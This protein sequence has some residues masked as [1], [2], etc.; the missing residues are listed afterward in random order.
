MEDFYPFEKKVNRARKDSKLFINLES[1][2]DLSNKLN[3]SRNI[4]FILNAAILS[5]MGKLGFFRA[6]A[7]IGNCSSLGLKTIITKGNFDE[8]KVL[9]LNEYLR[10]FFQKTDKIITVADPKHLIL[11]ITYGIEFFALLFLESKAFSIDYTQEELHYIN[12]V[13]NLIAS[14][15]ENAISYQTLLKSKIELE[16]KNQILSTIYDVNKDFSSLLSRDQV[17]NHLRYRIF[18]QLMVNRFVLFYKYNDYLEEIYNN[19]NLRLDNELSEILFNLKEVT[20]FEE[21]ENL[22]EFARSKLLSA[23]LFLACPIQ[24]QE[25]TKGLLIVGRK[26]NNSRFTDD[27]LRFIELLGNTLGQAFENIRLIDEEIKKK[28]IEREL[29]L[30]KT[31]QQN[32]FPKDFKEYHQIDVFGTS[33]PS[34]VVGGDYFDF[35]PID[36]K[37]FYF[38]IADV[39]GKG[40]PASLLMANVQASLR[41]L[42][43]LNLPLSEIVNRINQLILTNTEPD[44]FVTF[45]LGKIDLATKQLEYINA[46]HN[47]PILLR[48]GNSQFLSKGGLILG[49]FESPID[50]EIENIT[51]K[52]GDLIF[53]YTDGTIECRNPNDIE[54]GIN[55]LVDF[56]KK[57]SD[58]DSKV[59]CQK[60][61]SR[62][63]LF[64]KSNDFSDDVTF[65]AIKVK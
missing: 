15:L 5:L 58:V 38:A 23:S 30:A 25:Q 60:L 40:I 49:S 56:L 34:K 57:F 48:D 63:S 24:V 22:S 6:S 46:G 4:E 42:S 26:Y 45:F 62:L 31:I 54:F 41:V 1:L 52:Q 32:L 27:D 11:Y 18:G 8:S 21:N 17:V 53:A 65:I 16:R 20:L 39:S 7:F 13:A 51:L 3:K 47:P 44:K 36:D 33:L 61:I 59:L 12:I 50:F 9:F 19:T 2:L 35:I 14:A 10:D 37:S 43:K 55:K 28:Q 29:E 64:T